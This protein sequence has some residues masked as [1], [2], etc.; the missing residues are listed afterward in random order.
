MA[1]SKV[2]NQ[3]HKQDQAP[4]IKETPTLQELQDRIIRNLLRDIDKASLGNNYSQRSN[5]IKDYY[6][7]VAA[8]QIDMLTEKQREINPATIPVQRGKSSILIP[9]M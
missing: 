6:Q 9:K 5:C 1:E 7:F 8:V 4:K 2:A 3:S